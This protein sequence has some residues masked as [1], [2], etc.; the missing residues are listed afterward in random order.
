MGEAGW[1]D[2]ASVTKLA[3][4][5]CAIKVLSQ[6]E[7]QLLEQS[8]S[9]I[10]MPRHTGCVCVRASMLLPARQASKSESEQ[11]RAFCPTFGELTRVMRVWSDGMR[12]WSHPTTV[13][14]T[15]PRTVQPTCGLGVCVAEPLRV[16]V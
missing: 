13:H 1:K 7:K 2:G 10:D 5:I 14:P 15:Y 16:L 11:E 3:M 6:E 12:V 8:L 4:A 9:S